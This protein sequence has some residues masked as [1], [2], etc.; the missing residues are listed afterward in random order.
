MN[1]KYENIL[2]KLRQTRVRKL[3]DASAIAVF[4]RDYGKGYELLESFEDGSIRVRFTLY[5]PISYEELI[6]R[7]VRSEYSIDEEFAILRQRETKAEEF[8]TYYDFVE[9]CKTAARKFVAEREEYKH[10]EWKTN[11]LR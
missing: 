5:S 6:I 8:Q 7:L 2:S 10:G 3:L 1:K 11:Y 4:E 9:Q